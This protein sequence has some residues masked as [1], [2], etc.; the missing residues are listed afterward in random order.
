VNLKGPDISRL[1]AILSKIGSDV[2]KLEL[3]NSI[4]REDV[5]CSVLNLITKTEEIIFYDVEFGKK[6]CDE[7]EIDLK[8]HCLKEIKFFLCTIPKI[9]L[10]V[11]NNKLESIVVENCIIDMETWR[12]IFNQQNCL[13]N[14]E[15]DPYFLDPS[16][17][18]N[19]KL[20]KMK[21][22][23]NRHVAAMIRNQFSLKSLDLS[24]AHTSDEEFFAICKLYQLES[25]RLWIDR[26]SWE[27]LENL[28]NL[29][30]LKELQLNYDHLEV[31]YITN[32]SK[33]KMRNVEKLKLEFQSLKFTPVNFYEISSNMVRVKHLHL[34]SASIAVISTL[35]GSFENL[36][37]LVIG[38]DMDSSEVVDFSIE[39]IL[40]EKLK[41]LCIF[42]S[43]R[44]HNTFKCIETILGL[45]KISVP[46]LRKL[47]LHNVFA[48]EEQQVNEILSFHS[49]LT[50]FCIVHPDDSSEFGEAS[51][52]ALLNHKLVFFKSLGAKITIH[53]KLV[54]KRFRNKFS[55]IEIKAWKNQ[56]VLR[57]CQWKH[58]D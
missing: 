45:I 31:E 35:L 40:H 46:N 42:N 49:N 58:A 51:V 14:L 2:K 1:I 34:S 5:L 54:Q 21:L 7:R 39:N 47:K 17:M 33:I 8:L 24:R 9:I 11:P 27:F 13:K 20:N 10:K 41:D 43:H 44:D 29:A 6:D 48:L 32:V 28:E 56:I 22:M 16:S 23:S 38:C 30:N 55:F 50:H 26:I 18:R 36:E 52:I 3:C 57:E 19:L 37:T 25:L 12:M 4:I 53:K 15:F